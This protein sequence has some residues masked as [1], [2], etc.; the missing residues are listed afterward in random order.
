M[1]KK[2]DINKELL[3]ISK[4]TLKKLEELKTLPYPKHYCEV[5]YDMINAHESKEISS[6]ANKNPELFYADDD[7]LIFEK[8]LELAKKSINE[9]QNTNNT[10]KKIS[11]STEVNL[12]DLDQND[13]SQQTT[14]L[15]RICA[16]FQEQVA[17]Q[18]NI[19]DN[20]IDNMKK[21]I[22]K[23]ENDAN[24]NPLTKLYNRKILVK[25]LDQILHFGKEKKLNLYVAIFDADDFR[26]INNNFGHIAGNKTLIYLSKLLQSFL[27]KGIG[28]YHS[29]GEEFSI[30][31]NRS[32][33][34]EVI[35]LVDRILKEVS[36]SKLFY[37][38]NNI[39]LTLSAGFTKHQLND[40]A[41]TML[42][43]AEQALYQ[44]KKDGKNCFKEAN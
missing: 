8:S 36:Q 27:R 10:I 31:L 25:E 21:Q 37:K 15:L 13:D 38:G 28:L 32:S 35:S 44:A 40:I 9:F 7:N 24:I 34:E 2:I 43:R 26:K 4:K 1:N 22:E 20:T 14:S 16:G 17:K 33:Y 18:L 30:I 5:F 39:H 6:L 42:D 41:Q 11:S 29:G 23:L 3:D 19:A 12:E